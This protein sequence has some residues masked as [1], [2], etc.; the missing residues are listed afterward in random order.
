V[1]HDFCLLFPRARIR[2]AR[3]LGYHLKE[4]ETI[5]RRRKRCERSGILRTA[6]IGRAEVGLLK[7]KEFVAIVEPEL[8]EVIARYRGHYDVERI[9]ALGLS[10]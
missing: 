1:L 8:R 9:A 7:A 4:H 3:E 6:R 2:E 5:W 10:R